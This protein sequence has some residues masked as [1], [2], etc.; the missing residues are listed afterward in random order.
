MISRQ[1][2]L[3][4]CW[5]IRKTEQKASVWFQAQFFKNKERLKLTAR[6]S[7]DRAE[8]HCASDEAEEV[9]TLKGRKMA[10]FFQKLL[11]EGQFYKDKL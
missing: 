10:A 9:L 1:K 4:C 6:A 5:N 8:N 2:S 11:R 3:K 7:N